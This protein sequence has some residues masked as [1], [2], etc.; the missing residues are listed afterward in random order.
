MI[1]SGD[2]TEAKTV[3]NQEK[4]V[5]KNKTI[6]FL[7]EVLSED[8]ITPSQDRISALLKMDSPRN[9][10]KVQRLFGLVNYVGKYVNNNRTKHI[11]T[12]LC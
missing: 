6:T 7:S 2:Y 3:M 4:C 12:L 9:K 1:M 5:V 8:G 10:D 11:R